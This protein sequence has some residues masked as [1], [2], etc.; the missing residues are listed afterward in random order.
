MVRI[1][2]PA[3]RFLEE[4]PELVEEYK[5]EEMKKTESITVPGEEEALSIVN[6]HGHEW[7]RMIE[8]IDLQELDY[9]RKALKDA[10]FHYN[11][12]QRL[13]PYGCSLYLTD[14]GDVEEGKLVSLIEQSRE[15]SYKITLSTTEIPT[16][17]IEDLSIDEAKEYYEATKEEM[18]VLK[19]TNRERAEMGAGVEVWAQEIYMLKERCALALRVIGELSG[20]VIPKDLLDDYERVLWSE[21]EEK[22]K[23]TRLFGK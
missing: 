21:E 23:Q 10:V 8:N 13:K 2:L 20:G 5:T 1:H 14:K 18:D 4:Y 11:Q 7:K 3:L 22:N 6:L 16:K 15:S 17:N 12:L 19:E 9:T